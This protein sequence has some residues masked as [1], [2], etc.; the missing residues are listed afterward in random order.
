MDFLGIHIQINGNQISLNG[1]NCLVES[2][3]DSMLMVT[4]LWID[5]AQFENKQ[6]EP[7]RDVL[8][9]TSWGIKVGRRFACGMWVDDFMGEVAG[10][11]HYMELPNFPRKVK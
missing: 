3:D 2:M 7:S 8:I 11:T 5:I 4:P 1:V 6:C 9:N 10:V